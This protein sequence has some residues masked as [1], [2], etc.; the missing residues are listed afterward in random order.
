MSKCTNCQQTF[1]IYPADLEFYQR[2]AVPQPTLCP[3][4]RQQRRLAWRNERSLY[5]DK[6]RLCGKAVISLYAPDSPYTIYCQTCWLSDVWDPLSFGRVYQPGQSFFEQIRA[7]Q[8]VVPRMA[9][10]TRNCENCDYAPWAVAGKNLYLSAGGIDNENCLYGMFPFHSRD[11]MDFIMP[12]RCELCYEIVECSDC[13][14]VFF[15]QRCV[16]CRDCYFSYACRNC[17]DC[18][19]C[20]NLRNKKF[21]WFNE[22]LSE[23][24]YRARLAAVN[25][26]HET[27]AQYRAQLAKLEIALP[28]LASEQI[29][30]EQSSGDLMKNCYQ[31]T[32]GF[33]VIDQEQ[34]AYVFDVRQTK[35]SRDLFIGGVEN[36]LTYECHS[37]LQTKNSLGLN[38]CWDGNSNLFYCD[39]CFTS[40]NLF[41]CIGLRKQQYCILNKS[42]SETDYNTLVKQI[43]QGMTQHGEWGEFFPLSLS[44]FPYQDTVAQEYFPMAETVTKQLDNQVDN[45][46]TCQRCAKNYRLVANELAYYQQWHL[47]VP[48][49]CPQ[50]RHLDR[51]KL[52]NPRRLWHRQCM[53]K[54]CQVEFETTYAP[55][56]KETVYCEGCYNKL[57]Y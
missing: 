22:Q 29:N 32:Y 51:M 31:T 48:Q 2:M 45:L 28:H 11:C 57:I 41:G 23:A 34:T 8:L 7:L 1:T 10:T 39:H 21:C 43:K 9:I 26:T 24:D 46:P 42:Y 12:Y 19:G 52:R 17:S 40:Q 20:V 6:C 3:D 27:I 37:S 50:C 15:S 14:Q 56:R 25:W 5:A 35:D 13:Y 49:L 53:N 54:G 47:P 4:C 55:D 30:C 44:P 36:E 16:N 33:D 38:I 18:F